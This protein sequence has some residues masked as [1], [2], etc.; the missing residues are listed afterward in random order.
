MNVQEI[1]VLVIVSVAVFIA[2]WKLLLKVKNPA[3]CGGC[4]SGSCEGCEIAELTKKASSQNQK[5]IKVDDF[6]RKD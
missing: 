4:S 1:I 2:V 3:D 6:E 5:Q